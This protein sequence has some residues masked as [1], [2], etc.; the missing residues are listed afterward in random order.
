MGRK[1]NK[2]CSSLFGS[3]PNVSS[4]I[5]TN[6]GCALTIKGQ[7]AVAIKLK[8]GTTIWDFSKFI[9]IIT[10]WPA[11]VPELKDTQCFVPTYCANFFSRDIIS[12]PKAQ[13]MPLLITELTYCESV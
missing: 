2:F 12:G 3:I 8:D 10:A 6:F 7:L 9:A 4:S 5:S 1:F 11:D 13:F